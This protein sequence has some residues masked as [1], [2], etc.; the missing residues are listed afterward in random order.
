[1]PKTKYP[2]LI[3]TWETA[4][5]PKPDA[6]EKAFAMLFKPGD[7]R[8]KCRGVDKPGVYANVHDDPKH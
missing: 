6:L 8:P 7:L 2:H 1:M 4:P 3:V 5:D